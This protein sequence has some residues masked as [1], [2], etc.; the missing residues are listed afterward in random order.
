MSKRAFKFTHEGATSP[1][2]G[3]AWPRGEWVEAEGDIA[4]CANGIHACR[5]EALPR[6]IDD[7]LWRIEVD[8]VH[9]ELD[10]VLVARRGR[11]V[12]RIDSWD[13]ATARE[14]ARACA[15]RARDLAAKLSEDPTLHALAKD[16]AAN[17]E[18][19]DRSGPALAM[20]GTAHAFELAA[21]GGYRD[22][23]R[24][25]ADWLRERLGLCGVQSAGAR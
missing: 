8:G 1:F 20:Y 12:E 17:A 22:E 15:Q 16:I 2:T 5:V 4:L 19:S 3:Y 7:E 14:L 13:A 18:R 25:Q 21:A 10:G 9:E 11:L 24:R 6:W 23:R